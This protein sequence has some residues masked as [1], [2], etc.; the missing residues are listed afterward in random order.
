MNEKQRLLVVAPPF[1]AA[2]VCGSPAMAAETPAEPEATSAA[3]APAELQARPVAEAS[4]EPEARPVAEASAEP[5]ATSTVEAPAEP[6]ATPAGEA[7]A[8]PAETVPAESFT[9]TEA[10]PADSP[11][12][13]RFSGSK[14]D[15]SDS[16]VAPER[17]TGDSEALRPTN[18]RDIA[19]A[20][21]TR[22]EMG[23]DE[24]NAVQVVNDF[25]V[26]NWSR[27]FT[28]TYTPPEVRGRF[29]PTNPPSCGDV[30]LEPDNAY[31]CP[32]EDYITWDASIIKGIPGLEGNTFPYNVIAHEWGHAIQNRT[33]GIVESSAALELQADC[34][35]GATLSG[36]RDD[37]R[38][39]WEPTDRER[40]WSVLARISDDLPD[41][42]PRH[43]GSAEERIGAFEL[44]EEGVQACMRRW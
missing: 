38:L 29:D 21:E 42:D 32:T 3:E 35:A 1:I 19:P 17:A 10:E 33:R 12:A 44:G 11:G 28:G 43:H 5:E 14:A 16:A 20:Q 34:L 24:K 8:E 15:D 23:E 40:L 25:W 30:R 18:D 27:N 39:E 31:Y 26:R 6:Q 7:P 37:G 13:G 4:A 36:A 22:L 2:L 9:E 41:T